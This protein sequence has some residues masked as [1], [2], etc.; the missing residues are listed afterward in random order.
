MNLADLPRYALRQNASEDCEV[1]ML[2]IAVGGTLLTRP[3]AKQRRAAVSK[4]CDY[5]LTSLQQHSPSEI[6]LTRVGPRSSA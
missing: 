2:H 6:R 4:F 3:V 1:V 5:V